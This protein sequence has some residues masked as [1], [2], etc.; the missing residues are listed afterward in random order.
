MPLTMSMSS[1]RPDNWRNLQANQYSRP[2]TGEWSASPDVY[3]STYAVLSVVQMAQFLKIPP[4]RVPFPATT[5]L[6]PDVDG[7]I[8]RNAAI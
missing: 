4:G 8:R 2:K 6:P 1:R 5:L 3:I 7:V